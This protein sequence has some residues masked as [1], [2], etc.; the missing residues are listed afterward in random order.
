MGETGKNGAEESRQDNRHPLLVTLVF[1][2]LVI[3][4]IW[5][6]ENFL[7]DVNT[8]LFSEIRFPELVLYTVLSCILM[9]II[10]PIIRI[11]PAF[12]SGAV[13][14]FQIGFRSARR[15]AAAVSLT[16]IGVYI[17]FVST[18]VLGE[19]IG[20]TEAGALF[21]LLLPTAIAA[22]MICWAL[23][24]THIQAYVR[25]E[26]IVISIFAGTLVTALIFAFSLSILFAGPDFREI[27]F[28]LFI[29]GGISALFFLAVR[30]IYAT[31]VVV[32]SCLM[33]LVNSRID[34]GYLSP[35]S[36]VVALCGILTTAVMAGVHLHFS[37]HY[38]T[39]MLPGK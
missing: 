14:M 11:R 5:L 38:T 9:G 29:A 24:G 12:L 37:R 15:T 28:G 23:V 39:V 34:P 33:V 1:I 27:F 36:P 7:L 8:R 26:G 30:D 20:R 13:N 6:V 10:V 17:I 31:T 4:V 3:V 16:F 35:F 22:V 21:L 2:P 25:G 32:T 18:G 19:S